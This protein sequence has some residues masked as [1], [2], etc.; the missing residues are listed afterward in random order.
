MVF[1]T[2]MIANSTTMKKK[3]RSTEK[4]TETP[5]NLKPKLKKKKKKAV[6]NVNVTFRKSKKRKKAATKVEVIDQNLA[7]REHVLVRSL[8]NETLSDVVNRLKLNMTSKE[9][10][11]LNKERYEGLRLSSKLRLGTIL[12]TREDVPIKDDGEEEEKKSFSVCCDRCYTWIESDKIKT[13]NE[14]TLNY[15]LF[16]EVKWICHLCCR[17]QQKDKLEEDIEQAFEKQ[18]LV[19]TLEDERIEDT[20]RRLQLNV[21]PKRILELNIDRYRGL[22]L[23]SRT[24]EGTFLLTKPEIPFK[25]CKKEDHA[26]EMHAL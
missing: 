24:R 14:M 26:F 7:F 4:K 11:E 9:L 21:K 13:D 2:T 25:T 6:R 12:L 23:K 5:T 3:K 18:I 8:D 19:C 20:V 16:S 17:D 15:I 22:S 1:P 10:L